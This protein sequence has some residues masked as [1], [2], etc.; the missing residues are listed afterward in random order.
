MGRVPMLA[1]SVVLHVVGAGSL[2]A[3]PSQSGDPYGGHSMTGSG[4]HL[5]GIEPVG[6]PGRAALSLPDLS[7]RVTPVQYP[8]DNDAY[9]GPDPEAPQGYPMYAPGVHGLQNQQRNFCAP[10]AEE[11]D[12][13]WVALTQAVWEASWVAGGSDN[14]ALGIVTNELRAKVE[15]P[16]A[17]MLTISPRGAWHLLDGPV[18][19]DLPSQL[20]DASLETVLSLPVGDAWFVQGAFSPSLFTDGQNVSGDALRLPGRLL[21][22]WTCTESLTLS[23]GIVY[24]DRENVSILPAVG[25]IWKP[26]DDWRIEAIMPRPRVAWRY[27]HDD[28]RSSWLYLVGEFGGGSWA[29]E[30]ANGL[31]DVATLSDY[32]FLGGWERI[33]PEGIDYRVET[34]L[35]FNRS[36]EYSSTGADLDLPATALVRFAL[37]Y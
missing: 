7:P 27:D 28:V 13:R 15:F 4:V 3:Q 25:A 33:Q 20:Y 19:T 29:I 31:D 26:N 32:R 23:G 2:F 14:D 36:L 24:L 37:S 18:A 12:D 34:G 6:T 1:I 30:R 9:S 10:V 16:W 21:V 11:A 17:R 5:L 22:F 35:V 8:L